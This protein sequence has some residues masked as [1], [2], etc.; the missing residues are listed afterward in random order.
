V[1]GPLA[2]MTLEPAAAMPP[3]CWF[4]LLDFHPVSGLYGAP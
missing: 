4:T 1:D 3:L 2:G